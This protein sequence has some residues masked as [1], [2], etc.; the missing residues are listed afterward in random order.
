MMAVAAWLYRGLLRLYPRA[1]RARFA[2]D[3]ALDFVESSVEAHDAHGVSG[4]AAHWIR[5]F[6]NVF[7][8]LL[9]VRWRSGAPVIAGA[10]AGVTSLMWIAAVQWVPKRVPIIRMD[11]LYHEQLLLLVMVLA[12]LVPIIGVI[13]LNCCVLMPLTR[14]ASRARRV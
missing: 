11:T 3:M 7:A 12:V 9:L 8:T 13:V 2:S 5:T 4:L 10:A 1:F 6:A 14:R